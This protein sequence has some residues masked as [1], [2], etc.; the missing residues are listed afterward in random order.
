M[1]QLHFQ[2][3]GV[4][5]E[6]SRRW[7]TPSRGV[8]I[9]GVIV[10]AIY[11]AD[12]PVQIKLTEPSNRT[13][14]ASIVKVAGEVP[15]ARSDTVALNVNGSLLAVPVTD[16]KFVATVPLVP[17]ENTIEVTSGGIVSTLMGGSSAVRIFADIKPADIW[18]QLTWD[19]PGD[20]DLHLFL[21]NTEHCFYQNKKTQAGAELDIDNT[22]ADG[23]EHIVME[24]ALPGAYQLTV[25]YFRASEPTPRTV[26]WQV[27][28]RLRNKELQRFSGKLS[29]VS[30]KQEVSSFNF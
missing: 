16:A 6:Q 29:Q 12:P 13:T 10:G 11:V 23:P 4:S 19:G 3:D 8:A 20:I 1:R 17:G 25:V 15:G 21:P 26:T 14:T 27:V 22:V 30:E 24:H 28:V 7:K 9:A 5:A 2:A 18:T